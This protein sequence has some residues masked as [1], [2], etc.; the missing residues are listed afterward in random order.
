MVILGDEVKVIED[1]AFANCIYLSSITMPDSFERIGRDV[2]ENTEWWNQHED[3]VI[4][5][6]TLAYSFKGDFPDGTILEIKEGTEKI[7]DYAFNQCTASEITLPASITDIGDGAFNY[8]SIKTIVIPE[9]IKDIPR[10]AFESCKQLESI[11]FPE[12]LKSIGPSAFWTCSKL[13]RVELPSS[14][15]EMNPGCFGLCRELTTVISHI[16][17]PMPYDHFFEGINKNA[18]LH[19][20]A[21]TR[22]AY[23]AAGWNAD[24]LNIEEFIPEAPYRPFVEEGKVW[25][26]GWFNCSDT[27]IGLEYHYFDGDTIVG[28]TPCKKMMCRY[29]YAPSFQSQRLGREPR[30]EYVGAIYEENKCV[31]LAEPNTESLR[32][33]YDFGSPVGTTINIYNVE[34]KYTGTFLISSKQMSQ[35]D[36]YHGMS[37]EIIFEPEDF[38]IFGPWREGVGFNCLQNINNYVKSGLYQNL[39]SCTVN[40][41]V[42]YFDASLTVDP[43]LV[44][45]AEVK[46]H[47]LDFTHTTKPRP[48]SPGKKEGPSPSPSPTLPVGAREPVGARDEADGEEMVTGEYSAKE[49]FVNLKTLTGPYVVT[50]T[51]DNGKEVYR[52]E[53]QTSNIVALNTNLTKYADGTYTLVVENSEEQ[54]TATLALPLIDD[55]V[56]DLPTTLNSK[57]STHNFWYDLS[58]H[59]LNSLPTQKGIYI[60]DGKK[61]VVK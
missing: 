29:E 20:P 9:K 58:G 61:V 1:R 17:E 42:L 31:Y 4:Y 54:Y 57:P 59:R 10:R 48:K 22:D 36:T 3:G 11:T 53:V 14:I 49:L 12:H 27:A 55:A 37:T 6:G 51:D 52:K 33:I 43:S 30:T 24:I 28:N 34:L 45:I 41:E 47:W 35:D 21:G 23:I 46:K 40:D 13:K 44:D 60:R 39:M 32:L 15:S 8:S 7:A 2:F 18:T 56:R 26:T 16:Q 50:L 19:I 38:C 5:I 25:Q